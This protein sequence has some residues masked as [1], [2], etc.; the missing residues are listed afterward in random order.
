MFFLFWVLFG[1]FSVN[2]IAFGDGKYKVRGRRK[3]WMNWMSVAR[4]EGGW[5]RARRA[6]PPLI[7]QTRSIRTATHFHST[8]FFLHLLNFTPLASIS[9]DLVSSRSLKHSF[10]SFLFPHKP[11][12]P[13]RLYMHSCT[14]QLFVKSSSLSGKK[15][16]ERRMS[17]TLYGSQVRL[18]TLLIS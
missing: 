6:S 3:D 18:V 16:Q 7:L 5:E 8:R 9:F 2:Q 12:P 13:M 17:G 1:L 11:T 15:D 4:G 14:H 10:Q